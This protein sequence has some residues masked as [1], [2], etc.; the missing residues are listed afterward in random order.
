VALGLQDVWYG[1]QEMV[2]RTPAVA[3]EPGSKARVIA[4]TSRSTENRL[5]VYLMVYVAKIQD[6]Q[7]TR[8]TT[9]QI[10]EAIE[11]HLHNDPTLG[12][13]VIFSMVSSVESGYAIRGGTLMRSAR[14]TWEGLSKTRIGA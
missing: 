13:L 2:P 9:D 8:K 10:A 1:D 7:A 4:G 14:M 3:V 5:T 11:V 6:V 12:G